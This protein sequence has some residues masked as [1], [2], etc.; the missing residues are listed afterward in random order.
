ML[1]ARLVMVTT[2]LMVVGALATVMV[3]PGPITMVVGH[4]ITP[5]TRTGVSKTVSTGCKM[6]AGLLSCDAAS[7]AARRSNPCTR[8]K[9]KNPLDEP[10]TT[11]C[12]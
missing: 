6:T 2:V 11:L 3:S 10:M 7:T 1:L 5:V 9:R 4:C 8:T 12:K